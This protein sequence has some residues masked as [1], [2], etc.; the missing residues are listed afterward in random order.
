[1][2]LVEIFYSL[3]HL[4]SF[5]MQSTF[6][7]QTWTKYSEK[8]KWVFSFQLWLDGLQITDCYRL[9]WCEFDNGG[10]GPKLIEK[11]KK[12]LKKQG[13]SIEIGAC[14]VDWYRSYPF[15]PTRIHHHSLAFHHSGDAWKPNP[16]AL[17]MLLTLRGYETSSMTK[18]GAPPLPSPAHS[19]SL[20]LPLLSA[21]VALAF[22]RCLKVHCRRTLK[23]EREDLSRNYA[24]II[25]TVC[26]RLM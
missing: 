26:R 24:G 20:S 13:S 25:R 16:P 8:C 4:C 17:T 15:N 21:S 1:M 12:E 5:L 18:H 19:L 23:S 22:S 7:Y 10:C 6:K 11:V 14:A 9:R 3:L 2:H